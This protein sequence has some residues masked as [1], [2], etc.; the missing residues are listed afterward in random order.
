MPRM[1]ASRSTEPIGEIELRY[2]RLLEEHA[3]SGLTQREFAAK[4][5]VPATTLSWW[6][7]E[8]AHRDRLRSQGTG[9]GASLVK[10]RLVPVQIVTATMDRKSKASDPTAP[11]FVVRLRTGREVRV[12]GGFDAM[13]LRRLV[14]VLEAC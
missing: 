2:R 4:K 13:E 3:K 9:N 11:E 1:S 7:G 6:R 5:G 10:Q 8:I 14:E 12:R